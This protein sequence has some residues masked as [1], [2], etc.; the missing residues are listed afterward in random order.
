LVVLKTPIC[1]EYYSST[2][3]KFG[4]GS[5]TGRFT[6]TPLPTYFT[7]R[8]SS[9]FLIDKMCWPSWS[10][11]CPLIRILLALWRLWELCRLKHPSR[12]CLVSLLHNPFP[13]CP[14]EDSHHMLFLGGVTVES[15]HSTDHILTSCV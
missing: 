12:M 5:P 3:P 9:L 6:V 15:P 13:W 7:V 10:C 8:S 14:L 2:L 4:M 1:S 11:R